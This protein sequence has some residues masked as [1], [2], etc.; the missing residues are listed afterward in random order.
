M[1]VVKDPVVDVAPIDVAAAGPG[2]EMDDHARKVRE[3]SVAAETV[4]VGKNVASLVLFECVSLLSS[5]LRA[6]TIRTW[7]SFVPA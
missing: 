1:I 4:D 7:S 6:T 5:L 2:F 3:Y